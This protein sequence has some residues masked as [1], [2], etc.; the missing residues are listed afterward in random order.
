MNSHNLYKTS[1]VICMI[2][3]LLQML[4]LRHTEVKKFA[5][6][7]TASKRCSRDSNEGTQQMEAIFHLKFKNCYFLK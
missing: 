2:S 7:H 4:E 6:A 5:Q 3:P 1:E